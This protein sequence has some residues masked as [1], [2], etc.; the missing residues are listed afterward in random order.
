MFIANSAENKGA[1]IHSFFT[2][3]IFQ[4][5]SSFINN[6]AEYGGG[7]HSESS[8]LTFIH[9]KFNHYTSTC[10]KY[11][12]VCNETLEPESI[13][14][15]NT[16]SEVEHCILMFTL[17]LGCMKWHMYASKTIMQPSLVVSYILWGCSW[18]RPVPFS[19]TL[20][21]LKGVLLLHAQERAISWFQNKCTHFREQFSWNKRKHSLW[22]FA[23]EVQLHFRQIHKCNRAIQH[24]NFTSRKK[25]WHGSHSS[26]NLTVS[27]IISYETVK[28][29]GCAVAR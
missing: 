18:N 21:L 19:A 14:H 12:S 7:I 22:W 11:K 17:T 10:I 23:G 29:R 20:T 3:L 25:R 5:S 4:G 9:H 1:A 27:E 15:N 26:H 24:V 16:E 8:N 6:S 28:C 2:S 13:F